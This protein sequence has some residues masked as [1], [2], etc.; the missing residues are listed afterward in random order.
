MQFRGRNLEDTIY[1]RS[2]W[3]YFI[4]F[5]FLM[6]YLI[7]IKSLGRNSK[8]KYNISTKHEKKYSKTYLSS[9]ITVHQM[10]VAGCALCVATERLSRALGTLPHY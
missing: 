2:I 6:H 8:F 7:G 10:P 4:S 5:L 9:P 3:K 1:S